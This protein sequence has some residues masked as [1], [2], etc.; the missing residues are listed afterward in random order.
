[1]KKSIR[2]KQRDASDCGAACLASVAAYYD[3]HL[4]VS[5]I[6]QMA[7]TDKRGTNING[8][9]EAAESLGFAAKGVKALDQNY[10]PKIDSLYK[11]PKPAIAHIITDKNLMH[12]VVIYKVIKDKIHIMNPDTGEMQRHN[13]KDFSAIWT[14]Y[15]ILL[16][17]DEDFVK[18]N[19]KIS[20]SQRFWLLFKPHKSVFIQALFGSVIYTVLGLASSICVQKIID[21]VIPEG[22]KN[23][24]NLIC[25]LM[26]AATL[27]SLFINYIRSLLMMRAGI[28]INTRL[29]LGYY[30]HLLKL[31]QSFFDTMRSGEI[32]SRMGD[33]VRINSFIS[34]T[35]LNLVINIFTVIVS[36]ALMFSYYWKLAVI[37]LVVIPVYYLIY[38]FYNK[39]NR[40]IRRK[41]M[42]QG[43]E[44]QAQLV[45]SINSAGTIKRFGIENHANMKTEDRYVT[46]TRTGWR[47]G[48]Y[49]LVSSSASSL[50]SGLFTTTLYWAGTIFV[51]D[52]VITPGELMS[53]NTLTGYFMSPVIAMVSVSK[54]FQEAKIAADRLFEIFDLNEESDTQKIQMT[55]KQCGDIVFNNVSFRYGSRSNVFTDFNIKFDKGKIN[56]I[57]GESGSG[58]TTLVALL[59]NIYPL[60]SGKITIGD[61]D[62]K[63]VRNADLRS[64]IG[65]VPQNIELF[66]GSISD[67][68]ILDDCEPE[69]NRVFDICR[70]VGILEFIENLPAGMKTNTGENGVQLSGGQRQRLAIARVLYRNPEI[71][72]LDEATSSLD[73]ESEQNIKNIVNE[74]KKNGK[75]IILIAHRLGTVMTADKIFVLE[76]GLLIEE[77]T[78]NELIAK[79][80][81]YSKLWNT[82]TKF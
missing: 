42:E 41:L 25:I 63:H 7:G 61:I 44:L 21:Y 76:N 46:L 4:P 36:F 20:V 59:Q 43:A 17:P 49:D 28:Q 18:R 2:V 66:E 74:L 68:I 78:H 80:N 56:A 54:V 9:V 81:R 45:E 52:N 73:S 71:L 26:I 67:N 58:K 69:W 29:V 53:F 32:I 5:Q 57:V 33:A 19:E 79:E 62:I 65:I 1:M 3:L 15:L 27:L 12:F 13:I 38:F 51:L 47:S 23:L 30:K 10:K 40:V 77:G 24:L 31:P 11:I 64:L 60:Q 50:F 72:I 16:V 6:R 75:T 8:M 34:G 22:N 70:D 35:M 82:Q 14:G 39:A 55:N 48:I 37:M